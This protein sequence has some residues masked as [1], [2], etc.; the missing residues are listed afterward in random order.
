M[1]YSLEGEVTLEDHL[2]ELA[3]DQALG[4]GHVGPLHTHVR[5]T[6]PAVLTR[7]LRLS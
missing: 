7:L 1:T 4:G 6:H 2:P 5:L 3:E